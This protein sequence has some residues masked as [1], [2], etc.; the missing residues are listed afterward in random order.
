MWSDLKDHPLER[1]PE[2]KEERVTVLFK[3]SRIK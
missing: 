2:R 1:K 3:D